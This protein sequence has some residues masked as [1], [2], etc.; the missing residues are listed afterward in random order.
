MHY[1]R[2]RSA[3]IQFFRSLAESSTHRIMHE[4]NFH[5]ATSTS[6]TQNE[7]INVSNQKQTPTYLQTTSANTTPK[8]QSFKHTTKQQRI[9]DYMT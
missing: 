6:H 3:S 9:T 1:D 2:H 7:N 8:P 4:L 5:A